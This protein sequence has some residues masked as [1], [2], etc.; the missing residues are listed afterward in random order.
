MLL[1]LEPHL[2]IHF[3]FFFFQ[4][5]LEKLKQIS[6]KINK[7]CTNPPVAKCQGPCSAM[8]S[9]DKQFYR[10][11]ELHLKNKFFLKFFFWSFKLLLECFQLFYSIGHSMVIQ[12]APLFHFW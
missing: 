9:K 6:E 8:Y 12:G 1:I 7:P 5:S 10:Y 4:D 2:C 3:F 11:I